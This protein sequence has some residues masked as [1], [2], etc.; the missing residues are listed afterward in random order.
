MRR[1]RASR[2]RPLASIN[3]FT[4]FSIKYGGYCSCGR[5]LSPLRLGRALLS[6]HAAAEL[7]LLTPRFAYG[8]DSSK[9]EV[10]P[11]LVDRHEN[12][13]DQ[14]FSSDNPIPRQNMKHR[15]RCYLTKPT[16][17]VT[18]CQNPCM[19]FVTRNEDAAL[20]VRLKVSKTV[21]SCVYSKCAP[22]WLP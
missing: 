19:I 1:L 17:T 12:H 14:R 10:P 9:Q 4:C 18:I 2:A 5:R 13:H 11:R 15:Y 7:Y 20:L 22:R 6:L 8:R 21:S 16:G 3:S